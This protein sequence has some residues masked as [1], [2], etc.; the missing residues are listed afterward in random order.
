M[1]SK[2][3]IFSFLYHS[4]HCGLDVC[5]YD[6][7]FSFSSIHLKKR[8][9]N[10][11]ETRTRKRYPIVCWDFNAPI[12]LTSSQFDIVRHWIFLVLWREKQYYSF[13]EFKVA[14]SPSCS[15][16]RIKHP[17]I[18]FQSSRKRKK[19]HSTLNRNKRASVSVH[20]MLKRVE[21]RKEFS[22]SRCC[23]C[24]LFLWSITHVHASHIKFYV[25]FMETKKKTKWVLQTCNL[26]V[27]FTWHIRRGKVNMQFPKKKYMHFLKAH[28]LSLQHLITQFIDRFYS[29]PIS[30]M[31]LFYEAELVLFPL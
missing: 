24:S 13:L 10:E 11:N 23:T 1:L 14:R 12:N 26:V 4:F 19:T 15:V 18:Y 5:I 29:V 16:Y 6:I 2:L 31:T 30:T 22:W 7:V 9:R 8:G 21:V 25:L 28:S 27:S 17:S 3:Y 20:Y